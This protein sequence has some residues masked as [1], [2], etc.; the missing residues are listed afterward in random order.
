MFS[1]SCQILAACLGVL[2]SYIFFNI[3]KVQQATDCLCKAP[4]DGYLCV[5]SGTLFYISKN[6]QSTN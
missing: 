5:A 4:Y 1:N 3:G 6:L 2:I